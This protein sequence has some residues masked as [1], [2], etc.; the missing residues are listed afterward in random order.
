MFKSDFVLAISSKS[1]TSC[2]TPYGKTANSYNSLKSKYDIS[3]LAN[4]QLVVLNLSSSN[5][6][7]SCKIGNDTLKFDYWAHS[8]VGVTVAHRISLEGSSLPK[9]C[10]G[11]EIGLPVSDSLDCSN[12]DQFEARNLWGEML[13]F[14]KSIPGSIAE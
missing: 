3:Q 9:E 13:S 4:P 6:K 5:N 7:Y 12:L 1:S 2:V 11:K 14:F 10:V 8:P